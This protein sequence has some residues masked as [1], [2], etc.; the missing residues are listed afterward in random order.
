MVVI[1]RHDVFHPHTNSMGVIFPP[2]TYYAN[3]VTKIKS[4]CGLVFGYR[5]LLLYH[6]SQHE[7][8]LLGGTYS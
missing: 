6:S 7:Y 2:L 5:M 1:N 4:I 3:K 8:Y